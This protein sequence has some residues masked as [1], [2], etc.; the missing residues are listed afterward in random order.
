MLQDLLSKVSCTVG[1][2]LSQ[3]NEFKI[4]VPILQLRRLQYVARNYLVFTEFIS[5][6]SVSYYLPLKMS[7]LTYTTACS[8]TRSLTY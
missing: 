4:P 2:T 8:N 1:D 3:A 5:I 7:F 6:F